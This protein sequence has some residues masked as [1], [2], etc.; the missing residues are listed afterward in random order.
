MGDA[1]EALDP[2]DASISR[3]SSGPT[4]PGMSAE[5]EESLMQ[6][7]RITEELTD[8][9]EAA[10]SSEEATKRQLADSVEEL[11]REEALTEQHRRHLAEMREAREAEVASLQARLRDQEQAIDA[12]RARCRALQA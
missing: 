7:M 9:L 3:Q 2:E 6:L 5:D 10:K 11:R 8:A 1:D 12:E 4:A